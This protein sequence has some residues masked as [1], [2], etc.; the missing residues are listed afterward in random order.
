[1]QGG[2]FSSNY[3]RVLGSVVLAM[4]VLALASYALLNFK[5]AK[6]AGDYPAN[7]S[8]NGTGEVA[9]VPDVG[10][11]SFSVMAEGATAEEAQ[12]AS[13]AKINAILAFLKEQGVEDKDVKTEGYNMYPKYK[14]EE[15]MCAFGMYCPPGEQVQDGYEVSQSVTVKVRD[16]AKSGALVAGAGEKGATN[17]SGISFIVDDIEKFRA[18]ART[19]AIADAKT[20]ADKLA[21]DLGVKLVRIVSFY[22]NEGYYAKAEMSED[23][24]GYAAPSMPVGEESTTAS[25]NI[26]YEIK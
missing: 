15:R 17:I 5:S 11:F 19:K 7:I 2:F 14:Y 4:L 10:Q 21:A 25:V 6:T 16:T 26:T 20:K 22:E 23:M 18:E 3:N 8:V 13:A 24:G 12:G 1:M 9:A